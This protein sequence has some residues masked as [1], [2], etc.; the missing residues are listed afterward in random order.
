LSNFFR[1]KNTIV[2]FEKEKI[3]AI[4]EEKLKQQEMDFKIKRSTSINR[5]RLEKMEARN[6]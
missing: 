3:M 2:E 6:K 5:S 1:E 4:Y